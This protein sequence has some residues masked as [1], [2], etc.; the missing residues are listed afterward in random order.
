MLAQQFDAYAAHVWTALSAAEEQHARHARAVG[1]ALQQDD[2]VSADD[3]RA[4]QRFLRGAQA[5]WQ[6]EMQQRGAF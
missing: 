1:H 2:L 4:A 3:A 5:G 6:P